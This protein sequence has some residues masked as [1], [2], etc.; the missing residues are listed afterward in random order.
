M[1]G[2][3]EATDE[4]SAADSVDSVGGARSGEA[5]VAAGRLRG[6]VG[7]DGLTVFRGIPYARADRFAAPEPVQPWTGVRDATRHGPISPQPAVRPEAVMGPP[8]DG[9]VQDEDCLNL[10][11]ITPNRPDEPSAQRRPVL[12]WLH[13]GAYL[14][15]ASS[16][17]FYDGRRLAAEGNV[18]FVGLNYRLGALGYLRAPGLSPGN[19]GLLD[20]LAALRWIRENIAAFGGDPDQVTVFGQSAG[21]HSLVCLLAMPATRGLFRRAI[22]QST[23][24]GLKLATPARA[25]KIAGHFT[26]ALDTDPR[27]ATTEEILAAQASTIV[28]ASGPGG[29]VAPPFCPTAETEPLPDLRRWLVDA[30]LPEVDVMIGV[31]RSEMNSF[32]NR[33]PATAPIERIPILGSRGLAAF[34]RAATRRVFASPSMKFANLLAT[35]GRKVFTYRFDWAASGSGYGA[36]HCIELPFLLGD[37]EAWSRAPMLRGADWDAVD[38]L[39]HSVRQ[40]WLSFARTGSAGSWPPHAP[41][42]EAGRYWFEPAGLRAA[43]AGVV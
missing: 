10:T 8:Q 15:G 23:P 7:A 1:P 20:Q 24:L 40:A 36:C 33:N 4:V 12:V 22:L 25:R 13:G 11:V 9:L 17:G 14:T 43:P 21:A 2:R 19:L 35:A 38:E 6:E 26:T 30:T 3:G 42:A 5:V 39:G 27:Q 34:K 37:R 16:F 31:T 28:R 32:L 18:V 41:G 29:L